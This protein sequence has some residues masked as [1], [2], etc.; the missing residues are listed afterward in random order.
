[1]ISRYN[2]SMS[3]ERER[4]SVRERER[5]IDRKNREGRGREGFRIESL[6]LSGNRS[7]RPF[8]PRI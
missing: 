4:E 3:E 7:R 5:M 8:A 1:V 2:I 6:A